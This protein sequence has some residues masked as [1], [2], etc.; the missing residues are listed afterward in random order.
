MPPVYRSS[1][2]TADVPVVYTSWVA[3]CALLIRGLTG[4]GMP[5]RNPPKGVILEVY[6]RKRLPQG[7]Y[8]RV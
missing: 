3:G 6:E 1:L 4:V 7:L 5:L 8:P 2:Y